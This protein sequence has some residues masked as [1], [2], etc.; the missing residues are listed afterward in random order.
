M[1][2]IAPPARTG[3]RERKRLATRRAIEFAV[4][5]L[6]VQRGVDK[7]TIEDISAAADVS[8]RTFFNY[9]SSK[10]EALVGGL[11]QVSAVEAATFVASRAPVIEGLRELFAVATEESLSDDREVHLLRREIFRRHPHLFGMK[12]A[13]MRGFEAE[14]DTLVLD[15][16]RREG[17][18]DD[19][20]SRSAARMYTLVSLAAV[21]HAWACW[22][23]EEGRVPLPERIRHSFDELAALPL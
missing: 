17:A 15:R 19:A 13:G 4:L 12:I 22:A 1:T 21:R 8:P 9:F 6:T 16:L 7:V 2:A 10:D 18:A 11:P 5:S 3:L 14:L 23:D 20:R